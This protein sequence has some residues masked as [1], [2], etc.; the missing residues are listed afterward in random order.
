MKK[1][2]PDQVYL[3]HQ[4]NEQMLAHALAAPGLEVCGLL[5]G[6][7]DRAASIYPVRNIAQEQSC[8]FLMDP[9]QQIDAMRQMR[10]RGEQLWGI[11]HSHPYTSAEPSAADLEMA[12]YPDVYYF[13]VSM[14]TSPPYVQAFRYNGNQFLKTGII[15]T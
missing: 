13:V 5:G 11:Y 4:I 1:N 3:P 6:R 7:A 9:E 10:T 2:G 14:K 12:A 15:A 8:R